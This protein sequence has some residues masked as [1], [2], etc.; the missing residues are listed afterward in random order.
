MTETM[1]VRGAEV[2]REVG[3]AE[4]GEYYRHVQMIPNTRHNLVVSQE[5]GSTTAG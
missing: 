3:V 5:S 2:A 4:T 1:T